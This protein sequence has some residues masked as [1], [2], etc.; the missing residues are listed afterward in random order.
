MDI[1]FWCIIA[2]LALF[3]LAFV[4]KKVYDIRSMSKEEKITELVTYLKGL[5]ALV[6]QEFVGSGRGEEKLAAVK[7]M[8][9]KKAPA[10]LKRL[11]K[12]VGIDDIGVL[13]EKA[14]A[15]LKQSFNKH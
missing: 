10:F 1:A 7:E 5:V 9:D 6:E 13:I 2:G 12:S 11:L 15:E 8:F 3:G 4:V 14:L